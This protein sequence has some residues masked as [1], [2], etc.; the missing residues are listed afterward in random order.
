M[1]ARCLTAGER[2]GEGGAAGVA[3]DGGAGCRTEQ[4]GGTE[5]L[6]FESCT[7]NEMAPACAVSSGQLCTATEGCRFPAWHLETSRDLGSGVGG[8]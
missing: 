3:G 8:Q 2:G 7:A 6:E 1:A 5:A 4:E